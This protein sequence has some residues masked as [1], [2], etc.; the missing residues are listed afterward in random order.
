MLTEHSKARGFTGSGVSRTTY[1]L[2]SVKQ[3]E[4]N[5]IGNDSV[6]SST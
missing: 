3:K 2:A 4:F 1:D 5:S 6:M